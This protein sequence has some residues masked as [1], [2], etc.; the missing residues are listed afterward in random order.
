M[1]TFILIL[2]T[3]IS[4]SVFA[5]ECATNAKELKLLVGNSD[6]PMSW[7]ESGDKNPFLL[8]ISEKNKLLNLRL[9]T[10]DGEWAQMDTRICKK[11]ATKFIAEVQKVIWGPAAPEFAK[12]RSVKE[13]AFNLPYQSVLKVSI[14]I[15]WSGEFQPAK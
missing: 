13:V 14:S 9:T 5:Q 7:T 8:Q 11:S 4:F 6:F 3:L 12:G 1:K 10:K 2:F 15:F